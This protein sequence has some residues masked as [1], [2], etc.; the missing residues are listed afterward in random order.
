MLPSESGPAR[1]LPYLHQLQFSSL[2]DPPLPQ[3]HDLFYLAKRRFNLS[4][5]WYAA[6]EMLVCLANTE[7]AVDIP[8]IVAMIPEFAFELWLC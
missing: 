6:Y 5:E 7:E 2:S 8:A 4:Q 1:S 3:K